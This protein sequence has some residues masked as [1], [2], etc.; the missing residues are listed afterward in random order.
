MD[1]YRTKGEIVQ[2]LQDKWGIG[3]AAAFNRLKYLEVDFSKDEEGFYCTDA[4]LEDLDN[5]D[6]HLKGGGKMDEFPKRSSLSEVEGGRLTVVEGRS[7]SEVEGAP[8]LE[9]EID[10][11]DLEGDEQYAFAQ[12]VRTA[13]EKAAGLH[14][15]QNLLTA[16]FM[17][18]PNQLPDDLRQQVERSQ[19]ALAPKSRNPMDIAGEFVRKAKSFAA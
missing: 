12:L 5:L 16:E 2:W 4:D 19:V 11:E 15:A 1:R 10:L 9:G 14:I 8:E 3:R 17:R 6:V 18:D 7:L 13:Q